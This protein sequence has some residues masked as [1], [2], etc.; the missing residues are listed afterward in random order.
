MERN[1]FRLTAFRRRDAPGHVCG[2]N[3]GPELCRGPGTSTATLAAVAMIVAIMKDDV[4]PRE[5]WL[6]WG[7]WGW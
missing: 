4:S 5:T 2:R 6:K 7:H 3:L 1:P